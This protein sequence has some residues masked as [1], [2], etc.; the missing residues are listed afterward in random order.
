M[1]GSGG[2][3]SCS[4]AC[5]DE[6]KQRRKS[7]FRS[8]ASLEKRGFQQQR[9]GPPV[10][11]RDEN[12]GCISLRLQRERS[13]AQCVCVCFVVLVAPKVTITFS[14]GSSV[15]LTTVCI[16]HPSAYK[17]TP[18]LF[19][20]PDPDSQRLLVTHLRTQ[21]HYHHRHQSHSYRLSVQCHCH[22]LGSHPTSHRS[23][24]EH[25]LCP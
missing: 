11:R 24:L 3:F 23:S 15:S 8:F 5:P 12:G 16:W 9:I 6:W 19:G 4:R 1:P 14:F 22:H 10:T 18:R 2:R 7:R 13:K 17:A 25:F 21:T 20:S